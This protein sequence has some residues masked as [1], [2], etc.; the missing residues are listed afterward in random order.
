MHY[1]RELCFGFLGGRITEQCY[2]YIPL[3]VIWKCAVCKVSDI[4]QK[5]L[6]LVNCS[7][8]YNLGQSGIKV[9]FIDFGI[10]LWIRWPIRDQLD[11]Y[12][13]NNKHCSPGP[14]QRG[15]SS[16]S[17][18]WCWSLHPPFVWRQRWSPCSLLPC[19]DYAV[20]Q[21]VRPI[22]VDWVWDF[23]QLPLFSS[24][25]VSVI[26]QTSHICFFSNTSSYMS[27]YMSCNFRN[28]NAWPW[29]AIICLT[30]F[31]SDKM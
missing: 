29:C 31:I 2:V 24:Q 30:F 25:L 27:Q 5:I 19:L 1:A 10:T 3:H 7:K 22:V 15:R 21:D 16:H 6:W 11:G 18:T 28:H 8:L 23:N 4:F 12:N 14:K 17:H 26:F 20:Q 13:P 9:C